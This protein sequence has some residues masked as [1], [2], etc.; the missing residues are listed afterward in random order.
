MV[1]KNVIIICYFGEGVVLEGDF[2]VGFN[3]VVVFSCFVIFFCR[4]NGYV[5]FMLVEE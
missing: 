1:G 2:Y 3:M 5:I 4:N